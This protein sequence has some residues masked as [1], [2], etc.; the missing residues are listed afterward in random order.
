MYYIVTPVYNYNQP[1]VDFD[2]LFGVTPMPDPTL[3][4]F[5]PIT[6][7]YESLEDL[8]QE[9]LDLHIA[10]ANQFSIMFANYFI[11]YQNTDMHQYYTSFRIPK[12]SGGTRRIE[13]PTDEI[14]V[15]MQQMLRFLQ[16]FLYADEAAYA[17]VKNRT[18]KDVH[19]AHKKTDHEWFLHLDL[20]DFFG[21]CTTRH[22]REALKRIPLFDHLDVDTLDR[23]IH[24]ITLD[25]KLPQGTPLSPFITNLLMI[26]FDYNARKEIRKHNGLYTRYADDMVISTTSRN[27]TGHMKRIIQENLTSTPHSIKEEKTRVSSIY[28][29][30]WNL[31]LMYNKDKNITVGYKNKEKMRAAI[32]DFCTN[33]QAWTSQQA[34][35]LLGKLQYYISIEPEYF[36][37]ILQKY[38]TKHSTNVRQAIIE[39]IKRG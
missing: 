27:A 14:K 18:V 5:R 36:N 11:T 21:R 26:E 35:E 12:R 37:S 10:K 38:S 28:G 24:F 15:P 13:A 25:D 20:T 9:A 29:K 30:N 2:N 22:I 34:M 23:F 31:G 8:P 7:R 6:K 3:E 33:Q 32:N 19:L 4:S 1:Q 17:Y 39:K 16:S